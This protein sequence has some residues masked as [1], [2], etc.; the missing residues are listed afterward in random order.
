MRRSEL[1]PLLDVIERACTVNRPRL[2]WPVGPAAF[3]GAYLR[4]FAP[5]RLYELLVRLAFK[6]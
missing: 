4:R 2:R 6:I 1:P 5:D 3:S